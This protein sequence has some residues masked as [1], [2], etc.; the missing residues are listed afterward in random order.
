[1]ENLRQVVEHHFFAIFEKN[2]FDHAAKTEVYLVKWKAL[3]NAY[4]DLLQYQN[5]RHFRLAEVSPVN[6][7]C[8]HFASMC[9]KSASKCKFRSAVL[10]A[11]SKVFFFKNGEKM[12]LYHLAQIFHLIFFFFQNHDFPIFE[13]RN[14]LKSDMWSY[15]LVSF[16]CVH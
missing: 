16:D 3:Q 15:I 6:G 13:H 2:T 14:V 7:C 4:L 5:K 11:W 1:M 12:V 9:L 8:L 10:A